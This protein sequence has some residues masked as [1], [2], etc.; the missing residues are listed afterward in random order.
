MWQKT[1]SGDWSMVRENISL[2]QRVEAA[3]WLISR[4]ARRQFDVARPSPLAR[5]CARRPDPRQPSGVDALIAPPP[6]RG[7]GGYRPEHVLAMP[8]QLDPTSAQG[9]VTNVS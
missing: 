9:Y 6:Q 8:P 1:N 3:T 2:G 7:G 4:E 5:I